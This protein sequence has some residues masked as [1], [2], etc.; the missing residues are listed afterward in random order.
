VKTWVTRDFSTL[1]TVI[2]TQMCQFSI[3][4]VHKRVIKA[5]HRV[6]SEGH[7]NLKCQNDRTALS[8]HNLN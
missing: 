8:R 7:K 5:I 4:L 3:N 2:C 1:T 6:V